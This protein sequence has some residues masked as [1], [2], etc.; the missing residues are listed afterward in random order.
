MF[1]VSSLLIHIF[2]ACF[3]RSDLFCCLLFL[4]S[5]LNDLDEFLTEKKWKSLSLVWLFATQWLYSPR[6][7]PDQNTGV[8]SFSLLQ[9]IFPIKGSNLDLLHCRQ[10]FHQLSHQVSPRI[11]KWVADPF[12]RRSS[13]RRNWTKDLSNCKW[14]LYQLSYQGSPLLESWCLWNAKFMWICSSLPLIS[15]NMVCGLHNVI[16]MIEQR[17]QVGGEIQL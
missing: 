15:F 10:I 6:N 4:H 2:N 14:I 13:W 11:L 1:T 9:G 8:G 3:V 17:W 5:W 16:N 7:S 12:S